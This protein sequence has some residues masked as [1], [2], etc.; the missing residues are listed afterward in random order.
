MNLQNNV[1]KK[2][3]GIQK[4]VDDAKEHGYI[5]EEDNSSI[6]ILNILTQKYA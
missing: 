4:I 6:S 1:M 3:K 5:V 2:T